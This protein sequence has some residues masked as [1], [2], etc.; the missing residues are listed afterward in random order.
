MGVKLS[1]LKLVGK[2][3]LNAVSG[4]FAGDL[5]CEFLPEVAEKAWKDWSKE[6]DEP[7]RRAEVEQ[8][9]QAPDEEVRQWVR[10]TVKEV[11]GG[12]SADVQGRLAGYL[13]QV[14][15]CVRQNMRRPTDPTG[16]TVPA[17]LSLRKAS[18]LLSLLPKRPP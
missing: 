9:A 16:K 18:D 17:G 3:L 15:A 1:L 11:A 2:A 13:M 7:Q 4:G 10:E 6:K 14:P 5:V 12:Q 8:L